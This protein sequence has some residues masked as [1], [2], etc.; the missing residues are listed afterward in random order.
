MVLAALICALSFF[1]ARPAQAA[2]LTVSKTTD[3]NDGVCDFDCS[4]RE[5]ITVANSNGQ[6]DTIQF[7]T[8]VNV[9]GII[10]LTSALPAIKDEAAAAEPDLS[11]QGPGVSAISVSGNNAYG[12]FT[13]D[14]QNAKVVISKLWIRDGKPGLGS[15]GGVHNNG[16]LTLTD[17]TVSDNTSNVG[18]IRNNGYLNMHNTTVSA[19]TG[20][21][22]YNDGTLTVT[23]STISNNTVTGQGTGGGIR[24]LDNLYMINSTVSNN[25]ASHGGGISNTATAFMT[26]VTLTGNNS[27]RVG[28]NFFGDATSIHA[29]NTVVANPQGGGNNCF[30]GPTSTFGGTN[31][32]EYPDTSCRFTAN[33]DIQHQDPKLEPLQYNGGSTAT[34]RLLS[35][36]PAIDAAD[37]AACSSIDQRG[38]ARPYDGD[39]DG[40]PV[41]DIGAFELRTPPN[42]DFAQ[43]QEIVG[44]A[45]SVDGTNKEAS[46]EAG[47]PSHSALPFPAD[48]SVWYRWT[49]PNSGQATID[50]CTG[51]FNSFLAVYTGSAVNALGPIASSDDGCAS[52]PGAKVAFGATVGTTYQIVV[53]GA[54]W[55]PYGTFTLNLELVD[56][57]PPK[58]TITSGPSGTVKSDSATFKFASSEPGST[59][60]CSLDGAAFADCASPKSYSSLASRSHTFRVA[61]VDRAGNLD[62]TPATRTW[63]VDKILPTVTNFVPTSGSRTRDR[64]PAISA[65]VRDSQTN[66]AKTNIKLYLDG[67][68]VAQEGFA[69]NRQT[70]RLAYASKE[71]PFGWHK[72]MI[73]ARDAA[74]NVA[75]RQW[76][77][78]VVR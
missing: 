36:S 21:G 69:Y 46:R 67:E 59:F 65:I 51:D 44:S 66:L 27:P 57:V 22:I 35:G 16:S 60:R 23:S 37:N 4:L 47:E 33:G 20:G 50:T 14:D 7:A 61:A 74:G 10:T 63:T 76:R 13:I 70:D 2:T 78:K 5:A 45:A 29:Q 40:A 26:N 53:A 9:S 24:N 77:F 68:P 75:A 11:I 8:S 30:L 58:T 41:C 38:E 43:A 62:A 12:V 73:V 17:V 19:N 34:H 54:D 72:T 32:L 71:L 56:D 25:T 6:T 55:S 1:G 64:T 52:G 48:Y 31:N 28:A 49:A 15:G 39:F 18:G 42:D 3:T